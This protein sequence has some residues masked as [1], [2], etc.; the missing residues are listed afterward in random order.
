MGEGVATR[1]PRRQG[2]AG[3]GTELL[4][5]LQ[6]EPL[7]TTWGTLAPPLGNTRLHVVKLLASALSAS[8]AALTQELLALDVPNTLLVQG[9]K[10]RRRRGHCVEGWLGGEDGDWVGAARAS[11]C[12]S[13]PGPLLPLCVQQFL[14]R[15]S[16]GVCE[17][18]AELWASFQQQL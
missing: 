14:A 13:P 8:D 11:L 15:P 3:A 9:T 18:D 6:L 10:G 17:H 2:S 16:G 4:L 1:A 5:C 12:P 7:R